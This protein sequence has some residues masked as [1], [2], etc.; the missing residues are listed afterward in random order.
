MAGQHVFVSYSS[1]DAAMVR[2]MVKALEDG[3]VVCWMAPRD[4]PPGANFGS[5]ITEAIE[6]AY[7]MV[8]VFSANANANAEE[9][10]KEIVLASQ[11]NL[12]VVPARIENLLPSDRAFRYELSTRQ[13]I[14]LFD[15]WDQGVEKLAAHLARVKPGAAGAVDQPAPAAVPPTPP[16]L[17]GRPPRRALMAGAGA[18][19]VI[20]A[21]AGAWFGGLFGDEL[22][23]SGVWRSDF[24]PVTLVQVGTD[25]TGSW[26]QSHGIGQ[27]F[28]GTFNAATR[29]LEFSYQQIWNR[30]QGRAVLTLSADGRTF[31][32]TW[33]Q[34]GEDG[35][36]NGQWVMMR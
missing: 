22:S 4:V 34:R 23:I 15:N 9:I 10:K 16:A 24:G 12:I 19:A 30:A 25:V 8:L 17:A 31:S 21:G 29:K 14:D 32:G 28:G 7:A 2:R 18:A 1:R 33:E 20:A 36:R 5:A 11:S 27:I 26:R 3:G 13:W 35:P 6:N